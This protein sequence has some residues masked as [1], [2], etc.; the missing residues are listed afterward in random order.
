LLAGILCLA[1]NY[2]QFGLTDYYKKTIIVSFVAI[3]LFIF[4]Y[5]KI[6]ATG[7]DRL[8]PIGMAAIM[9]IV[10]HIIQ[11]GLISK[12]LDVDFKR[13]SMWRVAG[14][15]LL[16]LLIMLM[17]LVAAMMLFGFKLPV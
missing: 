1:I 6:P 5:I 13:K 12:H 15:I 14:I 10:T 11:G 4:T 16:S 3:P 8:W 9:W 17:I 7:Y 2:K